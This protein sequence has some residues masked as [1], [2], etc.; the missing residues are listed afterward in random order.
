MAI[1]RRKLLLVTIGTLRVKLRDSDAAP[2]QSQWTCNLVLL[3]Y[4]RHVVV[5]SFSYFPTMK[6]HYAPFLTRYPSVHD[7]ICPYIFET[8]AFYDFL[9]A[10]CKITVTT[11]CSFLHGGGWGRGGGGW[12]TR[13]ITL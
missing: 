9:K 1:V 3:S 12:V 5:I 11:R 4:R 10:W 2:E 13:E 6:F 8:T 7:L